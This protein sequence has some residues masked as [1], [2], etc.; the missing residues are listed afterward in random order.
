MTLSLTDRIRAEEPSLLEEPPPCVPNALSS[1]VKKL[2][3]V[4][5]FLKVNGFYPLGMVC[6]T[7][8]EDPLEFNKDLRAVNVDSLRYDI[9]NC[10]YVP[11]F[12]VTP[13]GKFWVYAKSK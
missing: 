10:V 7:H 2:V 1:R 6:C 11:C 9:S 5:T 4:S 13:H 3:S 8:Q 12:N